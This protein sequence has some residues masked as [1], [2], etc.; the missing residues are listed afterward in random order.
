MGQHGIALSEALTIDVRVLQILNTFSTQGFQGLEVEERSMWSE[1]LTSAIAWHANSVQPSSSDQVDEA[2]LFS[3][4]C[5]TTM[6]DYGYHGS[7]INRSSKNDLYDHYNTVSKPRDQVPNGSSNSPQRDPGPGLLST[8]T[9]FRRSSSGPSLETPCRL[10]STEESRQPL[11]ESPTNS[12]YESGHQLPQFD[13]PLTP[14]PFRAAQH[15]APPLDSNTPIGVAQVLMSDMRRPSPCKP[16]LDPIEGYS[17]GDVEKADSPT[18]AAE[19]N[20]VIP[21]TSPGPNSLPQSM[22]MG[23]VNAETSQSDA[24]STPT[25]FRVTQ[26]NPP[27]SSVCTPCSTMYSKRHYCNDCMSIRISVG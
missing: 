2:D 11:F 24:P 23:D 26:Y 4:G 27:T 15:D 13:E 3:T 10:S 21:A 5:K 6:R 17:F 22:H 9:S 25:P 12:L 14:T 18:I 7:D 16:T 20:R 19:R 1:F 8:E